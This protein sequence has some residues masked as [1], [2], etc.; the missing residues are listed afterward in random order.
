MLLRDHKREF[1]V[2]SCAHNVAEAFDLTFPV[3]LV[4]EGKDVTTSLSAL[5]THLPISSA[6]S[7]ELFESFLLLR[8]EW[9]FEAE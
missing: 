3:G 4:L 7:P 9:G 2:A 5:P 1:A 6:T 8:A